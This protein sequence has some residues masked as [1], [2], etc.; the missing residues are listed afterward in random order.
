MAA[1]VPIGCMYMYSHMPYTLLVLEQQNHSPNFFEN[2]ILYQH[3]EWTAA[4]TVVQFVVSSGPC[5]ATLRPRTS[6][7]E[8][9]M[10]QTPSVITINN[11]H[12]KP[13]YINYYRCNNYVAKWKTSPKKKQ[14]WHHSYQ[15]LWFVQMAYV[16]A[17]FRA[18][19]HSFQPIKGHYL[20]FVV[21]C[22][23]FSINVD[24]QQQASHSI[25][26]RSNDINTKQLPW[27]LAYPSV[28]KQF[29]CECLWRHAQ[30]STQKYTLKNT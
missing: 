15:G 1:L 18:W 21:F 6:P 2:C 26:T 3:I 19:G 28:I 17:K 5:W 29:S 27:S 13:A 30:A 14:L 11:L 8:Q 22:L 12:Q 16:Y 24:P 25:I 4:Y 9:R 10:L 23:L 7:N 20:C